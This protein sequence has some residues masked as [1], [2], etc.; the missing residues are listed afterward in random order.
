MFGLDFSML[1]AAEVLY[2]APR[3][4]AQIAAALCH[5]VFWYFW[6]NYISPSFVRPIIINM[7]S[8]EQ[9]L[10]Q[11][12]HMLKK[13]FLIDLGDSPEAKNILFE[14]T[15]VIFGVI[16]QHGVGGALCV[17]AIAGGF[18]LAPRVVAAMVCQGGLCEVGFEIQDTLQ[19]IKMLLFDGARGKQFNPPGFLLIMMFHH[20]CAQCLVIPNNIHY[21]DNVHYAEG[22][23]LLQGAAFGAF[24]LQQYGY[25]LDIKRRAGLLQMKLI[26]T[27]TML[28]MVWSRLVRYGW[29]W[30]L[31][32]S[33]YHA[34][35][36]VVFKLALPPVVLMSLFNVLILLDAVAKFAKFLPMRLDH[37]HLHHHATMALD[38][39]HPRTNTNV[40]PMSKSHKEWSKLKGAVMMGAFHKAKGH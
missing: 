28:I 37:A 5:A 2:A 30:Y 10:A 27:V 33:L 26:V 9:L 35:G 11:N 29:L 1:T 21:R 38:S 23:F 14:T 24:F 6:V 36:S 31:L 18:G 4:E 40:W 16:M 15:V 20:T 34:D 7:R 17:P 8:K 22:V 3:L 19:R 32:I 39:P 12:K 25:T 13:V